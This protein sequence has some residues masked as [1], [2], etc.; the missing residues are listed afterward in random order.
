MVCVANA[1]GQL[2]I[3]QKPLRSEILFEVTNQ[4]IPGMVELLAVEGVST[5]AWQSS[6][7]NNRQENSTTGDSINFRKSRLL[8]FLVRCE[9]RR[10]RT[11]RTVHGLLVDL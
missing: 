3:S 11:V 10:P 2:R 9:P 8:R 4:V 7:R 5:D 1:T 6:G